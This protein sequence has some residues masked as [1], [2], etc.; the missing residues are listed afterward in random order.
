MRTVYLDRRDAVLD[1]DGSAMVVRLGGER[2]QT[3]PLGAL[4]RLV[5]RAPAMLSTRLLAELC[6]RDVG[7]LVLSGRRG[8]AT[9]RLLGRPTADVRLRLAQARLLGSPARR[10]G[11]GVRIVAAKLAA[12][13]RLLQCFREDAVGDRRLV[14]A[15]IEQIA[16]QARQLDLRQGLAAL[17]GR[18]G[19]AGAAYFAAYRTAFAPAL[20]FTERNR[21]PPRDPV[22]VALSLGYTLLH[23]EAVCAA[24]VV[25][26]D[27]MIG[28]LHEPVP[29]RESLACDLVEPLR[30]HVDRLAQALF[31]RGTLRAA[32]FAMDGNACRL[33]KAGR[34]A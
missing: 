8:E 18:E 26:L 33:G 11:L 7:L 5:V 14:L 9:A 16:T 19:A 30:P 1:I 27:P 10:A 12:Q 15:A 17:I 23:H 6:V 29:G 4:E 3:L 25:G 34:A 28:V 24:H 2:L 13:T 20:G 22:N 21:R 31:A 32:H